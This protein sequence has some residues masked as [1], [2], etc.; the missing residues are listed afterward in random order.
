VVET[1]HLAAEG[2]WKPGWKTSMEL[3][4]QDIIGTATAEDCPTIEHS[5]VDTLGRK[6]CLAATRKRRVMPKLN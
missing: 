3:V 5:G 1:S 2:R 4:E 6:H